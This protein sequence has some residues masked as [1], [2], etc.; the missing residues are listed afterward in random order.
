M[1]NITNVPFTIPYQRSTSNPLVPGELSREEHILL[2]SLICSD[3]Q[4]VARGDPSSVTTR[5][6]CDAI[7]DK[8]SAL[9]IKEALDYLKNKDVTRDEIWQSF[10]SHSNIKDCDKMERTKKRVIIECLHLSTTEELELWN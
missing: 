4:S 10:K 2:K 8:S 5:E 6:F 1:T 3:I 9:F 7:N